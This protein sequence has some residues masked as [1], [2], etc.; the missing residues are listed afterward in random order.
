[1]SRLKEI[2]AALKMLRC[3]V[4]GHR[5]EFAGFFIRA[6]MEIRKIIQWKEFKCRWCGEIKEKLL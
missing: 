4:F 6:K 2:K 3:A 5:Y 1:M